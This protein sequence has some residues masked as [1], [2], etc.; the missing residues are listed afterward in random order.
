MG[1]RAGDGKIYGEKDGGRMRERMVKRMGKKMKVFSCSRVYS[2]YKNEC[3]KV[4]SHGRGR[5]CEGLL[6]DV[7]NN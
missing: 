5:S 2:P 7:T 1:E 3:E 4:N 6:N